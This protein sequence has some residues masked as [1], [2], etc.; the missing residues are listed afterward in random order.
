MLALLQTTYCQDHVLGGSSAVH[1]CESRVCSELESYVQP[2]DE[3]TT[4][5]ALHSH[6]K[7][8]DCM[9]AA[10]TE[11]ACMQHDHPQSQHVGTFNKLIFN[12]AVVLQWQRQAAQAVCSSFAPPCLR[13]IQVSRSGSGTCVRTS[14]ASW[15]VAAAQ[16]P[17][18]RPYVL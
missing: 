14:A 3:C 9:R 16:Q 18:C 10:F 4:S 6:A 12:L 2:N 8:L 1:A 13:L 5:A 7:R 11:V 15:Y 17:N